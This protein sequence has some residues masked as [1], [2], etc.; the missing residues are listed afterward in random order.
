MVVNFALVR[1]LFN[2]TTH[3]NAVLDLSKA[4]DTMTVPHLMM[5]MSDTDTPELIINN[6][7]AYIVS[8]LLLMPPQKKFPC[9]FLSHVFS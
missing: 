1:K 6:I 4:F 2:I 7:L 5:N 8:S 9:V 3:N